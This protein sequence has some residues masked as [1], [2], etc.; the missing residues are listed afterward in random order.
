MVVS[1][2]SMLDKDC[3]EGF[4]E[5]SFP[6]ANV[7]P[8]IVLEMP[9]LTMNNTDVDFQARDLQ[10][11]F[12]TTGTPILFDKKQDGSLR[13]CID[14]RGINNL[15]IKNWYPLPLVG[16]SLDQ[17]DWAQCFTQLDLTNAYH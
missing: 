4:F 11:R 2:F 14:Y 17:L 6:L 8:D 1:T 10:W 12:Y 7:K 15:T 16:K 13:L 9:F 5:E 3:R